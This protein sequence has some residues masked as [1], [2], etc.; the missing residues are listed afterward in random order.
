MDGMPM[1]TLFSKPKKPDNSKQLA[2]MEAQDKELK[3]RELATKQKDAATLSARRGRNSAR[4]SLIT[5][6]NETGV[7]RSELG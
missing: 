4:A 7:L 6:G 3:A 5:G 2:M 1:S